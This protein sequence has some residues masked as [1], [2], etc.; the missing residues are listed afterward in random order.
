MHRMRRSGGR[1]IRRNDGGDDLGDILN[2]EKHRATN[3]EDGNSEGPDDAQTELAEKNERGVRRYKLAEA[4]VQMRVYIKMGC[5][6][7]GDDRET[8]CRKENTPAG[9]EGTR[10]FAREILTEWEKSFCGVKVLWLGR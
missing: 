9:N 2:R 5:K 4:R 1:I 6:D 3:T 7:R 8:M 10:R